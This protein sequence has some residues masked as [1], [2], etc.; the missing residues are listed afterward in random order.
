MPTSVVD[1]QKSSLVDVISS[2]AANGA[3]VVK[4]F[5]VVLVGS[6]DYED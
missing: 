5:V 2:D 6:V 1:V 3:V 4:L